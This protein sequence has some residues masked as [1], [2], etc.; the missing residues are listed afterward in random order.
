METRHPDDDPLDPAE[1]QNF[2]NF[3][4]LLNEV[5]NDYDGK[6]SLAGEVA[7]VWACFL[8]DTWVWAI[9]PRMG[10]VLRLLSKAYI[11]EWN[12]R[13]ILT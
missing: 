4:E 5:E 6:G 11:Q 10:H 2:A 9:T 3:I 7:R 12:A 8:D 1:A 13:A